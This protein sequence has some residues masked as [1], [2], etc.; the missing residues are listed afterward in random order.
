MGKTFSTIFADFYTKVDLVDFHQKYENSK[1]LKT[2]IWEKIQ[3]QWEEIRVEWKT[4]K[5]RKK[6]EN[7]RFF[8]DKFA[9]KW[10]NEKKNH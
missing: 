7:N 5:I 10:R 4:R 8:F 3:F 9:K 6:L 2:Q 1:P